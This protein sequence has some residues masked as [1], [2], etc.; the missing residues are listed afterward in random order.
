MRFVTR[1]HWVR[2]VLDCRAYALPVAPLRLRRT[3]PSGSRTSASKRGARRFTGARGSWPEGVMAR[4][5][6]K[7][8]ATLS[9]GTS[10]KFVWKFTGLLNLNVAQL[11]SARS[12]NPA[13]ADF[14]T[15][16]DQ[17]PVTVGGHGNISAASLRPSHRSPRNR[18]A[19][20]AGLSSRASTRSW[21]QRD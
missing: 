9:H 20:R 3:V 2:L 8:L 16:S 11:T 12:A 7:A 5:G 14:K 15:R 10:L 18:T 19:W 6:V 4:A 17:A 1:F 13:I 21:K